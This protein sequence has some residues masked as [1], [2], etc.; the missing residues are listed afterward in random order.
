VC[1]SASGVLPTRRPRPSLAGDRNTRAG[2]RASSRTPSTGYARRGVDEPAPHTSH[3]LCIAAQGPGL[4]KLQSVTKGLYGYRQ[5]S[6]VIASCLLAVLPAFCLAARASPMLHPILSTYDPHPQRCGP[7]R[8][9]RQGLLASRGEQDVL[10]GGRC[11]QCGCSHDHSSPLG[12]LN[13][14]TSSRPAMSR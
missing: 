11:Q 6:S 5:I 10:R 8:A 9:L 2:G 13:R 1:R 4:N 14:A 3:E 7:R 12:L